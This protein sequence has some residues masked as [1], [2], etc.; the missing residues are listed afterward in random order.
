MLRNRCKVEAI[1]F[2]ARQIVKLS[3]ESNGFWR[4]LEGKTEEIVEKLKSS[5]KFMGYTNAY[6][7][8][9][10]VGVPVLKPDVNVVNV[11]YRLG[12]ITSDKKT[13][14]T[15]KQVQEIGSK[16]AEASNVK[17]AIVDYV[18][19]MFGAGEKTFVH[20]A[21][22]GT[23]A[24]CEVCEIRDYCNYIKLKLLPSVKQAQEYIFSMTKGFL[25]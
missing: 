13:P 18:L 12:L 5:F 1:V 10:Y 17:M 20:Y 23:V 9:R 11:L 14:K 22:C 2:N 24:K 19:Y 21:I 7:F 25:A 3:K 6:A 15:F 4:F 16:M 8:L